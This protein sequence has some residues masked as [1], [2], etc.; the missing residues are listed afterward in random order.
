MY[1]FTLWPTKQVIEHKA[2][3]IVEGPPQFIRNAMVLHS[4]EPKTMLIK[5]SEQRRLS[6]KKRPELK[7][8]LVQQDLSPCML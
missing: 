3:D 4:N 1:A 6:L 7:D 2:E 8:M 5:G